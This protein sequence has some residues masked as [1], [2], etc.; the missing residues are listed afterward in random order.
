MTFRMNASPAL[1]KI[2]LTCFALAMVF[3]PTWS[4]SQDVVT[5][6]DGSKRQG[7]II[8]ID[9][10]KN[11]RIQTQAAAGVVTT[12]VPLANVE[13]VA[14]NPP[15]DLLSAEEAWNNGNAAAAAAKLETLVPNFLGLPAPWVQRA[16]LLLI[17][18]LLDSGKTDEA[19][20]AL[21]KFQQAYPGNA[22]STALIRAKI[23]VA[24]KNFVGARPLIAPIIEEAK[25]TNLADTTQSIKFGQAFYLMGQIRENEGD[26]PGA[27]EDYLRSS[28]IFFAD[29][30]T[31]AKAQARANE[32]ANEKNVV[33][34]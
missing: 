8:G 29:G 17:D 24:R 27:L 12:T 19:E 3:H 6:N 20:A 34:P 22:D 14:M 7:T 33:V 31:A 21:V 32:L 10:Q 30:T 9:A 25:Q 15:A 23:A 13:S 18:T 4:W 2:L 5:L 1:G 11:I 26:L 16:T 28:I